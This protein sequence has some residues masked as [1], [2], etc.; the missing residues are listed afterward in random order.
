MT[1]IK[2]KFKKCQKINKQVTKKKRIMPKDK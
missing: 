2:N 1:N